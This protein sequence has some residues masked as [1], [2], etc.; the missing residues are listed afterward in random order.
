MKNAI[1]ISVRTESTR[2]PEKSL[3]K[4]R[5]KHTIEY[6]IEGVKKSKYADVIVLC[7]TKK[8]GDEIL[9]DIARDNN[10]EYFQGN[11]HNKPDRW[12]GA[13]EAFSVDF[14][15]NAD[16]DDLFFDFGLADLCFKE[17]LKYLDKDVL[18]DGQGLY[19]DVY[20]MNSGAI[21]KIVAGI[22]S[23]VEPHHLVEYLKNSNEDVLIRK[24]SNVPAIYLKND[25]RM[26][27]DYPDD[28]VFFETVINSFGEKSLNLEDILQFINS[29][30][31]VRNINHYLEEDWQ[32]NQ[33][34]ESNDR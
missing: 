7:T 28:L 8:P 20:A 29:N 31:S 5:G 3:L 10:I 26:T 16:G 6:L 32:K 2:L 22:T 30:P 25:I 11:E 4:I 14:F 27:L 19:N 23:D 21:S 18:I 33:S 12:L 1:F 9:C 24:L 34:K 17:H 15:V 13:C